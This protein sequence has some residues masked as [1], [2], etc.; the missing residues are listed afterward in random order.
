MTPK[1]MIVSCGAIA[2]ALVGMFALWKTM[3]GAIPASQQLLYETA[4]GL[5][6]KI[7]KVE[8]DGLKHSEESA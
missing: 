1:Q 6:D 3:G 2:G 4:G 5:E 8:T 7:H